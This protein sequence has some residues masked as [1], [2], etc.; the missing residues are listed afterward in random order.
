M[1]RG[2]G[3]ARSVPSPAVAGLIFAA[4]LA[5]LYLWKSKLNLLAVIFGSALAGA[6]ML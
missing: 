5:L 3:V 6:T 1:E 4:S 2:Y